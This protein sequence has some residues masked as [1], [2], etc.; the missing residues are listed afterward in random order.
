MIKKVMILVVAFI[1][2]F[3]SMAVAADP[4]YRMTNPEYFP[5]DQ[6]AMIVGHIVSIEQN[7]FRI[8]VL[9]ILNGSMSENSI[10][11]E[12]NFTY[13][14]FSEGHAVSK[15]GDFCIMAI[16]KYDDIYKARFPDRVVKAN[17]GDYATLKCLYEDGYYG[18]TDVPP[19]QW[20]T[21]SGGT[22]NG[23]GFSSGRAYVTRPNGE[24]VDIT[25][26]ALKV[27]FNQEGNMIII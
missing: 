24:M 6:D 17:S 5:G 20:Y 11:V 8:S 12:K 25:D 22:E 13:L 1:I 27:I 10:L 21:N 26:I 3:S 7:N 14:S 15:V 23:F 2:G 4:L 18:A 9:K 19:I 16:K